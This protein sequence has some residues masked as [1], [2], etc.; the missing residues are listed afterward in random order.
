MYLTQQIL[1]HP[2]SVVNQKQ[3]I[4]NRSSHADTKNNGIHMVGKSY[5]GDLRT[6][7]KKG[8]TSKV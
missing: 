1:L 8:C 4:L 3:H 2:N 7:I 6:E 5:L